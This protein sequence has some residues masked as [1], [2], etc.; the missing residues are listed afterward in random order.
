MW[1]VYISPNS[2]GASSFCTAL[3]PTDIVVEEDGKAV[4][5]T[6]LE[7][8]PLP[9]VHALLLDTSNSMR[10]GDRLA[11]VR[12]AAIRYVEG[13]PP[14]EEALVAT[15]DD[16]MTLVS[17]RTKNRSDL[18][19]AISGIRPGNLTALWDSVTELVRYL[20]SVPGN[21]VLILLSDGSDSSSLVSQDK[22]AIFDLAA[23][24]SDLSIF[25]VG[26][27][28][29]GEHGPL[30]TE[31]ENL[32]RRLATATGGL[33]LETRGVAKLGQVFERIRQHLSQRLYVVYVPAPRG[34]REL[35]RVRVRAR[36]GLPCRVVSGGPARR[37]EEVPL[38]GAPK[39]LGTDT[40]YVL[41]P[42]GLLSGRVPDVVR[43]RGVL[44]DPATYETTGTLATSFN[45]RAEIALREIAIDV[46]ALDTVT[47]SIHDPEDVLLRLLHL[48]GLSK[49]ECPAEAAGQDFI[50]HG[51]TF[52]ELRQSIGLALFQHYDR[53]RT[54]ATTR[55]VE[56]R[57]PAIKL[58]LKELKREHELS[59]SQLETIEQSLIDRVLDPEDSRP[60]HVLAEW[61]G[62][63]PAADLS[64]ALE[65]RLANAI[66]DPLADESD[67]EFAILT[68][69]SGWALLREWFPPATRVRIVTPLV[70]AFDERRRVFGFYRV[71]L[72][73]PGLQSHRGEPIPEAPF[74]VNL[75]RALIADGHLPLYLRDGLTLEALEHTTVPQT[76]QDALAY[77]IAD[78]GDGDSAFDSQGVI[79]RTSVTLSVRS[80]GDSA[81]DLVAYFGQDTERPI[82]LT[83]CGR[84]EESE[85]L[86][87]L[88]ARLAQADSYVQMSCESE[89]IRSLARR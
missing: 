24:R 76:E 77:V 11:L 73:G 71:V 32:M 82:L 27:D 37:R 22:Q 56:E 18:V 61:L 67:R 35:H 42:P 8:R 33:Y 5:V 68:A 12:Q 2:P 58:L 4:T 48:S 1:P 70:P 63:I 85:R 34:P 23:N 57:R 59:A 38:T 9:L 89:S 80:S 3:K 83:A 55:L 40:L 81:V 86:N 31:V 75:I 6:H 78:R 66:L 51:K 30:A 84:G 46:P 41:D 20:D 60:Q 62:D 10:R 69:E 16:N 21:K 26:L 39:E 53:Y 49:D 50:V 44:F 74:A 54:W 15:F 87:A 64:A 25:P 79:R 19:D 43:D 14:D 45:D 65:L 47:G 29:A 7:R 17:P 52:L 72:P 13:L 88:T 36:P 28:M